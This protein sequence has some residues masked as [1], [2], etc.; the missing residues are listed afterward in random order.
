MV[1]HTSHG[2]INPRLL[3]LIVALDA[4]VILGVVIWLYFRSDDPP[5]DPRANVDIRAD[6]EKAEQALG[7]LE[8]ER[9]EEA[10]PLWQDLCARFPNDA[11]LALNLAVGRLGRV[12]KQ[13]KEIASSDQLTD[14][15]RDA[16]RK[17]IPG[18]LEEAEKSAAQAVK[19][20]P[21]TAPP[22]RIAAAVRLEQARQLEYP[23]DQEIKKQAAAMIL[24][25]LTRVPGDPVLAVQLHDL[26][27]ELGA[28]SP[29][30][31][32]KS[33]D[34]L[35]NAWKK[36]PRN[37]FL[38][39]MTGHSLLSLRDNR[40]IELIDPSI[41]LNQPFMEEIIPNAAG[42]DPLPGVHA[43]K[44]AVEAGRY[45]EAELPLRQWFNLHL[46]TNVF[47]A[48]R[49]F[50]V[51]NVLSM[52][53]LDTI[54][55]WR[56]ELS[57]RV[58]TE[59]TQSATV[60]LEWEERPLP[61]LPANESPARY[62]IWYD[63]N[64]DLNYDIAWLQ[65]SKLFVAP[66][67]TTED[68]N[69]SV[70]SSIDVDP[71]TSRIYAIDLF[72]V[73]VGDQPKIIAETAKSFAENSGKAGSDSNAAGNRRHDT[74]QD[75]VLL[76][77]R[78]IQVITTQPDPADIKK[79]QLIPTPTPTGLEN[80]PNISR[81]EPV[82]MDGDGDLDLAL[83]A[84]GK[85]RLYQNNGNRTF[86]SIDKWSTLLP[87]NVTATNIVACDYDRDIDTDLLV[88]CNGSVIGV[89]DN[90]LHSQFRWRAL[91][92]LWS[93]LVNATDIAVAELDGNASWDWT[94]VQPTGIVSLLTR[95]PA[96]GEAIPSLIQ[97]ASPLQG[98]QQLKIADFNNDSWNDA[99][100]WGE[101]GVMA[102]AGQGDGQ[103]SSSAPTDS[104]SLTQPVQHLSIADVDR[105][106]K[107]S[108]LV[109]TAAGLK[110]FTS[111]APSNARYSEVR[112]RGID[113]SNG[114]GRVNHYGYGSTL[115][116]RAGDRYLAQ[117]VQ[118]PVT[119]FGLGSIDNVD[120]L[121]SIF[122]NGVTQSIIKPS[123][124]S[125]IEEVQ[126]PKGSCPFLYG[127][128][129]EK[130]VMITDLLWNAPLGL[131]IARGK[132]LPD[133][134]WEYLIVPGEK[135]QPKDG[136][137]EIRITEELWEAAYFDEVRLIA[138]DHPENVNVF[139]NEK[140]GPPDIATPKIFTA[141]TK[142]YPITAT[143]SAG[144]DWTEAITRVDS[145]YAYGFTRSY[146]QGLVDKHYVEFDFGNLPEHQSAQLVLTGWLFPTDTS[147]N[148][149][150]DHNPD[151]APPIPPSLWL[152]DAQGEFHCI[153]PF[154]GFP[155]GKP[156]PIVIDL[157]GDTKSG[158]TQLRIETSAQLHWDEA[159]LVIDEPKVEIREQTLSIAS[160]QLHYRGFSTLKPRA[161]DQPHWYDYNQLD[162]TAG[163]P[164]MEGY[165]T[166]YGDVRPLLTQ[167]DNRLVVMGS[168]DEMAIKFT[169]PETPLPAGWKRDF[170]LYS[171]GWDKDADLN[172]LEGQSSL[173]LPFREM[174]AYPP[175][176]RQSEKATEVWKLNRPNLK[177]QQNF[178]D[179]WKITERT[180]R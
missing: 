3:A 148:I 43:A 138:V 110:L 63:L 141:S 177:R 120:A 32:Q 118:S 40:L 123:L 96:V 24:D 85:V 38:L 86:L 55:R 129:G 65:G 48:D 95:T 168:G 158:S 166:N 159:F 9:F 20:A 149:G 66:L 58:A 162:T 4:I 156:K 82:D 92:G 19:L 161:A 83:I 61:S 56:S 10:T 170:V 165:F 172:T 102:I 106:G 133:R 35:Y 73:T 71:T 107:L 97:R 101:K 175:P 164:Y 17:E 81:V 94:V 1:R 113:D 155:G 62:A 80:V 109:T 178:R 34:A 53:S 127:W 134:R 147:L 114:G 88:A 142:R 131:Q 76:N 28:D 180:I 52:V 163:W 160:A 47:P 174:E 137:Y 8:N 176:L 132:V 78:G 54:T 93:E 103:W 77:D 30:L 115:E 87:D 116:V 105:Q 122:T 15:Q 51:P 169:P 44:L 145:V 39:Q 72:S 117:V 99:I 67:P 112:L 144:R 11:S 45:D 70:S 84:A 152:A 27:E 29:E 104:F 12:E 121:R 151:L 146:C 98:F 14:E 89:L 33:A 5:A 18:L 31:P 130:F 125:V 139:T 173:P 167:D 25:S 41:E 79:R 16:L 143:D 60:T 126:V 75:L 111:N 42:E 140:V 13:L 90:V 100:V 2:K 22:L 69:W 7:F 119:H 135:M 128:D 37:L 46:A 57:Q 6:L 68:K 64:L 108:I 21:D 49:R 136:H 179:F 154:M 153:R 74:L 124:S 23:A 150:L 91:D 50:A 157:T 36:L 171:T 26:A 59:R